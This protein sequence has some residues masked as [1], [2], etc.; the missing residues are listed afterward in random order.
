ML[1]IFSAAK[2]REY[3]KL[4]DI[5]SGK[6]GTDESPK[7]AASAQKRKSPG[8]APATPSRRSNSQAPT[9]GKHTHQILQ[10]SHEFPVSAFKI[11]TPTV[12]RTVIGPTP[13]KDGQVLGLFDLLSSETPSKVQRTVFGDI[14]PNVLATPSK[15]PAR[16]DC[17]LSASGGGRASRTPASSG[18]RFLL[19]TFV[20]PQKRKVAD[21]NTPSSMAKHLATPSFLRRDSLR[22]DALAEEAESPGTTRPW[23]KRSFGRSLSSMI[24]ELRRREEDELDEEWEIM[25]EMEEEASNPGTKS[26][27]PPK[28]QVEDSQAV[29]SLGPDGFDNSEL[30][31]EERDEQE[32]GLNR[33]GQPRKVWKKKG[34]KRQTKRIIS[35]YNQRLRLRDKA[36]PA[37]TVRPVRTKP[38]RLP[39]TEPSD[40][41]DDAVPET[42]AATTNPTHDATDEAYG[43]ASDDDCLSDASDASHTTKKHGTTSKPRPEAELTASKDKAKDAT[44]AVKK[45]G[46]KVNEQAHANYCRLKIKNKN[47]K[48]NGRGRFGRGRR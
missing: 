22:L 36:N 14:V 9:P 23:K 34:Q 25:R 37:L 7:V 47:S 5:L 15:T 20:T 28:L 40:E 33:N 44:V 3:N 1:T 21:E 6:L 8:E 24:Q 16:S 46:R 38:S 41:D 43:T 45:A 35:Q 30:E 48:A 4:R 11:S 17:E 18:K 13:Q 39:A 26:S 27:R 2:Y 12:R 10:L 42:Q 19:D 31:Q 29:M 32:D